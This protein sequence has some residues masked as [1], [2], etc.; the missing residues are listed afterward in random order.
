MDLRDGRYERLRWAVASKLHEAEELYAEA[1]RVA[2]GPNDLVIL[3]IEDDMDEW[4]LLLWELDAAAPEGL[5]P[6][7]LGQ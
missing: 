6:E 7:V 3:A 4:A 2:E 1:I 5:R